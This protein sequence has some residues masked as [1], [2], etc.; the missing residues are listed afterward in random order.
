MEAF[1]KEFETNEYNIKIVKCCASCAHHAADGREGIRLCLKGFGE[2]YLDYL[3]FNG[4]DMQDRFKNAGKGGGKV[5]KREYLQMLIDNSSGGR[6]GTEDLNKLR[7]LFRIKYG[8]E[9]LSKK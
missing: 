4:W 1:E 8:S 7:E 2:H 6:L 9:Y 5:K 3:C